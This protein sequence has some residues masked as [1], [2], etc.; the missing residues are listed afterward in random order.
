[1]YFKALLME[2]RIKQW[3]TLIQRGALETGKIKGRRKPKFQKDVFEWMLISFERLL[4]KFFFKSTR[5]S[6]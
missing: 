6:F 2:F 3:R 4:D 5:C 1:M